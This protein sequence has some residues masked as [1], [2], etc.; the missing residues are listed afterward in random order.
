MRTPRTIA[1]E[2]PADLVSFEIYSDGSMVPLSEGVISIIISRNVNK[3][4]TAKLQFSD[5]DAANENFPLSEEAY[6]EPGKSIEIKA[7]YQTETKSIFK[8]VVTRHS[9]KMVPYHGSRLIVEC[10]HEIFKST[11]ANKSK[12]FYEVS[13][14]EIIEEIL[15]SYGV[16]NDVDSTEGSHL[17]M[18]QM[19]CTDWD[20][21]LRRAETNG[22]IITFEDDQVLVKK[23]APKEGELVSVL[24][25]STML[26][27][28]G[29]IDSRH[30][31]GGVKSI[32]W[33]ETQQSLEEAEAETPDES[34]IS[35]LS[36]DDLAGHSGFEEQRLQYGGRLSSEELQS[37][38]NATLQRARLSKVRGRVRFQGLDTLY[39]GKVLKLDGLGARFNGQAFI[40]GVRHEISQG[41]WISDVEVG[42]PEDFL[43]ENTSFQKLNPLVP[44]VQG[45]QVGKVTQ[46]QDD[47][48]GNFRIKVNLPLVE[49]GGEGVWARIATL[50]AGPDRG[51]FFHPE[52]GDEVIL[53]FL[54]NDP[55]DAV[56][57]GMLHSSEHAA[58]HEGSDDNHE[59]GLVTRS[60]MRIWINDDE[61]S[62]TIDT[63]NGNSIL[64]SEDEGGVI[65]T[66]ENDNTIKL[67][68][69]GI[70]MESAKDINITAS[71]DV[72][73]EGTNINLKAQSQLSAEG[74]SGAELKSGGTTDVKGS[75]VNIN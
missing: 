58:P 42:L 70:T 73:V 19:D 18:V 6:F 56:V 71:G 11:L 15:D 38:A 54:Q 69:D 72:N 1:T 62:L 29:S 49:D 20:F 12:Y 24:H 55:R 44:A 65:I 14:K 28:E 10:K 60:E 23:P 16:V 61:V 51:T 43:P 17:N 13:D 68:A 26:E 57:L 66:D 3:I 39:P 40:S 7:G 5:G 9:I 21:L 45:L 53:G 27:F 35:N 64:L 48:D 32:R 25:G 2:R 41:D 31:M 67:N 46:L 37:W 63:P 52:I 74:S 59:K 75:L 8:G 47:P 50:D 34:D 22:L 30:Q 36:A 33:D 4:P